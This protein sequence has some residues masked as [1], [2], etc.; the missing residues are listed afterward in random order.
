[1]EPP[2]LRPKLLSFLTKAALAILLSC[3]VV[4]AGPDLYR[5][6]KG[7]GFQFGCFFSPCMCPIMSPQPVSGTFFLTSN[8]SSNQFRTYAITDIDWK[9]SINGNTTVVTGRG[10]YSVSSTQQ[11][12][13]ASLQMNGGKT[14]H[15]DSGLVTNSASFPFPNIKVSICTNR[16][17][18]VDAV[19]NINASPIPVPQLQVQPGSSNELVV[20]WAVS[21]NAFVL[22]ESSDMTPTSWTVVTNTPIVS[23]QQNQV[24]LARSPGYNFYRLWPD[25][26]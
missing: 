14:E 3:G 16:Q 26:N 19:F 18:C 22:Q 8:G 13:T 10:T 23:G 17:H 7:S 12:F 15:F 4:V 24:V 6:N 5:L 25:G 2:S 20:S 9:Y 21:S 1:M 11:Q